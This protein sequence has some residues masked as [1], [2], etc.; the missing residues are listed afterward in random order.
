[1]E[2]DCVEPE[3]SPTQSLQSDNVMDLAPVTVPEDIC[4]VVPGPSSLTHSKKKTIPTTQGILKVIS[5]LPKV[6]STGR[7]KNQK[8]K[9]TGSQVLTGSPFIE[10]VKARV[11]LRK[12]KE[13]RRS[14]R[15][16]KQSK[17][18]ILQDIEPE[19]VFTEDD[20]DT[21]THPACIYCNEVFS[22]S[23]SAKRALGV[24]SVV[25]AV[26]PHLVCRSTQT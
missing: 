17:R 15:I 18:V 19:I 16:R 9:V 7:A 8:K 22:A 3:A 23:K 1:M 5:P 12:F 25:L 6:A 10:E 21:E 4:Q 14:V 2:L 26:V 13:N 11:Q 24:L 20:D